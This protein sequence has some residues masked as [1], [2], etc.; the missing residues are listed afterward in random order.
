LIFRTRD[1][2]TPMDRLGAVR[3]KMARFT[4]RLRNPGRNGTLMAH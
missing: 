2:E 4:I 1:T 3:S